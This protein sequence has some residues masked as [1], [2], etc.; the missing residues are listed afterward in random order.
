MLPIPNLAQGE[1]QRALN[2]ARSKSGSGPELVVDLLAADSA[3]KS[4]DKA[5]YKAALDRAKL[6]YDKSLLDRD[7]ATFNERKKAAGER[8]KLQAKV[9]EN[10]WTTLYLQKATSDNPVD[11]AYART[12][13]DVVPINERLVQDREQRKG[14]MEDRER[15]N[16]LSPQEKVRENLRG[17][18]SLTD[19]ELRAAGWYVAP[20]VEYG[21]E[22][23]WEKASEEQKESHIE[24]TRIKEGG[25]L[26]YYEY[27]RLTEE[28]QKDYREMLESEGAEAPP[29][30]SA[31]TI[32][33]FR[34][35]G[36]DVMSVGPY[37]VQDKSPE[38]QNFIFAALDEKIKAD[39][40]TAGAQTIH[41]I[42][43]VLLTGPDKRPLRKQI[44][45]AELGE[46]M[47]QEIDKRY[48]ALLDSGIGTGRAA[49]AKDAWQWLKNNRK[50]QVLAFENFVTITLAEYLNSISGAAVSEPE[51]KRHR[52]T[53]PSLEKSHQGNVTAVKTKF[54]YF[55]L[56]KRHGLTAGTGK[57]WSD[58]TFN[59]PSKVVVSNEWEDVSWDS[60]D[61]EPLTKAG[62]AER[63]VWAKRQIKNG[64]TLADVIAALRNLRHSD[65]DILEIL[66][67]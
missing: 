1:M 48:R 44:N 64:T 30:S 63:R 56:K 54:K 20:G 51:F 10:D 60:K 25:N 33:K 62:I 21:S 36:A 38:E 5:G 27:K 53:Y 14:D 43:D 26:T 34:A 29:I 12:M 8:E 22:E 47:M 17:D 11:R 37:L 4:G 3:D 24:Y 49:R 66:G 40:G 35:Y 45:D 42:N 57:Q 15:W 59:H 52:A 46:V 65:K 41:Y 28:E 6:N 13:L 7:V 19:D 31:E 39:G 2:K 16:K 50:A 23:W 55:D 58:Y 9:K 18:Q 32:A 61:R 67:E